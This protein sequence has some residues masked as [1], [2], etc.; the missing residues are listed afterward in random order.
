MNGWTVLHDMRVGATG[1]GADLALIVAKRA[2]GSVVTY[3]HFR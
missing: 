1:D 3:Q 2:M